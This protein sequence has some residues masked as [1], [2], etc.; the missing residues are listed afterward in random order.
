M[1]FL[2][3]LRWAEWEGTGRVRAPRQETWGLPRT[4]KGLSWSAVEMLFVQERGEWD[5]KANP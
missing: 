1:S 2:R 3:M 4:Q 5:W